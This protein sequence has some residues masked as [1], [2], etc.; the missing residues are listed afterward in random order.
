M[1]LKCTYCL[2]LLLAFV[3]GY[4][5]CGV[6]EDPNYPMNG[7]QSNGNFGASLAILDDINGD[8]KREF[9]VGDLYSSSPGL[10]A[11]RARVYSGENGSLLY[12][13]SSSSSTGQ[14]PATLVNNGDVN[15]DGYQDFVVGFPGK[16]ADCPSGAN[17]TIGSAQ[18]ISGKTGQVLFTV[19]GQVKGGYFGL[20]ARK[21]GDITGDGKSEFVVT[22]PRA[23]CQ[24]GNTCSL[25][26]GK[27]YVI[28]G[29]TGVIIYQ[30]TG[31]IS[32]TFGTVAAGVGDVNADGKFDFA[33][34]RKFTISP[35][36]GTDV[37]SGAT[38]AV[39]FSLS[40][41]GSDVEGV[42][43]VNADGRADFALSGSQ[44]NTYFAE[45]ISGLNGAVLT[46]FNPP[47]PNLGTYGYIGN[48]FGDVMRNAGD[49]NGDGKQDVAV[50][51]FEYS[52]LTSWVQI[53][54]STNGS[55][56]KSYQ[57]P[58]NGLF[59]AAI[60][61]GMDATGD[62]SLDCFVGAPG[63]SSLG[64]V[65]NGVVYLPFNFSLACKY[66]TISSKLTVC[67]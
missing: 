17:G 57:S 8:G 27:T 43:D 4:S 33:V 11:A 9:A 51:T 22:E 16:P 47:V 37:Y 34:T 15:G 65:G 19:R 2:L 46:S 1:Q 21:I 39:I 28:S 18:M 24:N 41:G 42:G 49:W 25:C 32:G 31:A 13:V 50:G 20:S 61:S 60:A 30:I 14:A 45:V 7:S 35:F 52:N 6:A 23:V 36:T 59:G 53:L 12:S 58:S 38:G 10:V 54:S 5:V 63:E 3:A 44:G 64:Q 48:H 26:K 56:I 66:Y 55:V 67:L 40:K 62:G 29:A